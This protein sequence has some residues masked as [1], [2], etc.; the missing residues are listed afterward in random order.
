VVNELD[1]LQEL[2][3]VVEFDDCYQVVNAT[4]GS[5]QPSFAGRIFIG[6]AAPNAGELS[7]REA[8]TI[9]NCVAKL[10]TLLP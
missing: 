4:G 1:R 8:E 5:S 7:Q 9:A 10:R 3:Q 6:P 2:R